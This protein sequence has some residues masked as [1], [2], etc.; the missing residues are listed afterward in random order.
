METGNQGNGVSVSLGWDNEGKPAVIFA[1][2]A[3]IFIETPG[4]D[5]KPGIAMQP[6][7]ARELG[8]ALLLVAEQLVNHS[9]PLPPRPAGNA[10]GHGGTDLE[11][12]SCSKW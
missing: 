11:R 10:R 6:A 1:I 4:G 12:G 9:C 5:P 7:L 3:H 2:P 8:Y